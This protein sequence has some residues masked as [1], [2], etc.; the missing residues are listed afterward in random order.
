VTLGTR[1][2]AAT[3][4]FTTGQAAMRPSCSVPACPQGSAP[5][6]PAAFAAA[7]ILAAAS[8]A[9]VNASTGTAVQRID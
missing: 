8:R 2:R 7:L 6:L 4:L 9:V 1:H 5:G 3:P